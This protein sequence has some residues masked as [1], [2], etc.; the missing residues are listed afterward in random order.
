LSDLG[1][2]LDPKMGFERSDDTMQ[3]EAASCMKAGQ[4]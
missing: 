3:R 2:S 1:L 4:S